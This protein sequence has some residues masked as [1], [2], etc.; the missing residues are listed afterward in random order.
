M[1]VLKVEEMRDFDKNTLVSLGIQ[2]TELMH[3]AGIKLAEDFLNR[4]KPKSTDIIGLLVGK[5]NNGGDALVMNSILMAKGYFTQVFIIGDVEKSSDA[6]THYFNKTKV[7]FK[8]NSV[9]DFYKYKEKLNEIKIFVDGIFGLGLSKDITGYRKE[10]I[11]HVNETKAII[12]SIDIPSGINPETG[13]MMESAIKA[14]FTGV[15]GS[16]KLGNLLNDALDSHGEVKL[17]D[18]GIIKQY[19]VNR[20]YINMNDYTLPEYHLDNNTHKYARGLGLFIGGQKTMM[21]SIQMSAISGMKTGLGIVYVI[22]DS[23]DNFTKY[24][25]EIVFIDLKSSDIKLVLEKA[26]VVV[27]GPGIE[28][29]RSLYQELFNIITEMNLPVIIDAS[30]LSYIDLN[31]KYKNPNIIL[32]P[33]SGELANIFNVSSSDINL[34]PLNYINKLTE[35]GFNVILKGQTTIIASNNETVFL[36]AKN[37]GLATA[38]SG[39]VLSGILA[40]SLFDKSILYGM[41]NGVVIHSRAGGFARA[42]YGIR[43]M[44]ATD[45]I[46]SI[47]KVFKGE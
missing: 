26:K 36:Q 38:G 41:I 23:S 37:P 44:T 7:Y 3:R 46:N 39:D 9:K 45:I 5:G 40:G 15:I 32:T 47:Y 20:K 21:G 33:H 28:I 16:Y 17:L 14:D 10:L 19:E 13:I 31:E 18:I 6:F 35:K 4:L 1:E 30:G 27:F 2:E 34:N 29:N 22:S 12:Y 8:V 24:Y 25:P 11:N 43:S 42:Q